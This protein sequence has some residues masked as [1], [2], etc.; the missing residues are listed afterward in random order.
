MSSRHART[1]APSLDWA[2][3][4]LRREA[5]RIDADPLTNSVFSLA[6]TLFRKLESDEFDLAQLSALA[7][8]VHLTLLDERAGQFRRQHSGADPAAAWAPVDARLRA[9]AAGSF[10]AFKAAVETPTGGIVFTAH[11]T[12]ALSQGLRAALA[13]YVTKPTASHKAALKKHIQSDGRTWNQSITLEAEHREAQDALR[14]A[15]GAQAVYAAHVVEIARK[16]FPDD[17]QALRPALPT[18]AS[19]VGYD[20]DGRT[21][22]PWYRSV[23]LRLGEKAAQLGRYAAALEDILA[24]V[25]AAPALAALPKR[26][27][28]A[29]KAAE[30][31][32]KRFAADLTD[33]DL[34]V[35]AAN[36][37][38]ADSA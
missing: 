16:A 12:F 2:Q 5:A 33:P 26:L 10:E 8:E 24:G 9:L 4:F 21:D 17:W 18:I 29:A 31:H 36:E 25:K 35:A 28:R 30:T 15:A 1:P 22:I 20:L 38:T 7:E 23:H 11:P 3:D 27:K 34:L 37:L 13:A 19:W 6:Q 14:H 32:A